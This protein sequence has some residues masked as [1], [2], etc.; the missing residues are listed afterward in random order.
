[1]TAAHRHLL[2]FS[3]AFALLCLSTS[4]YPQA[5]DANDIMAVGR[6]GHPEEAIARLRAL[7]QSGNADPSVT[8]DLA[9]LL[10]QTGKVAEAAALFDKADLFHAPSYAL[11]AAVR[12]FR[13]LKDFGHAAALARSGL[14]RFPADSVW[15]VLLALILADD[16]KAQE[17]L[18]LLASERARTAPEKE[19]LLA[20]AYAE[21]RAGRPF[22]ALRHYFA[23]LARQPADAEARDAVI[24]LLR[25][26]RAPFAAVRMVAEPPPLSLAADMAA[27]EVRWD[28]LETPSD[29]RHRFDATDRALGDLDHLIARAEAESDA[30]ELTHLRLD[31]IVALRDR[32][33][34]GEVIAE[35]D[36]LRRAGVELPAFARHALADA[37]LYM[38]RPE[39]ARAEYDAVLVADRARNMTPCL[40]PIPAIAMPR[41]PGRM[42]PWKWRTSPPPM[43]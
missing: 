2:T 7:L 12:A 35:A 3:A 17:A 40:W 42:P 14:E 20:E 21:R 28:P 9:T 10:Q 4:G 26:V 11:L 39:D 33:R 8:L 18:S 37:L 1:V 43:R 29:P 32:V 22:D 5:S 13:D 19:Y 27:A 31:R 16:G 15:P 34:M 6:A 30:Q 24:A 25:E 38:R 41:W 23:V 36:S